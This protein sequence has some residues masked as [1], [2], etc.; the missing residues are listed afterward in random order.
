M[1]RMRLFDEA[2]QEI[3]KLDPQCAISKNF[4]RQLV[5]SGKIPCV[6]AGRKRLINFDA[7]LDYLQNPQPEVPETGIRKVPEKINRA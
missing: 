7:L 5:L 6:M 4:V 3:K 2:V 1:I